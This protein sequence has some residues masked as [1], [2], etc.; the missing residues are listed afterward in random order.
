MTNLFPGIDIDAIHNKLDNKKPKKHHKTTGYCLSC[1]ATLSDRQKL[2][3]N[4]TLLVPVE[5]QDSYYSNASQIR[6]RYEGSQATSLNYNFYTA[7]TAGIWIGDTA[8]D[9]SAAIDSNTSKFAWVKQIGNVNLNFYDKTSVNIKEVK[10][11]GAP[12]Y[13]S[14]VQK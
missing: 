3:L 7:P 1:N 14:G 5:L 11:L 12:S 2:D 9:K 13:T 10:T 6:G 4:G 8:Y